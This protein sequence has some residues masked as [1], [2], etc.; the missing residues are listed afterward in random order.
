LLAVG[1]GCGDAL[2]DGG[3]F[4][5]VLGLAIGLSRFEGKSAGS[6]QA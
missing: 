5:T 6:V 2:I 1:E 3:W 4:D